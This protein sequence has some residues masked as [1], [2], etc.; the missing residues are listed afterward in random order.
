MN[1]SIYDIKSVFESLAT[2]TAWSLQLLKIN[3]SK[4]SH[5]TYIGREIT[6]SPPGSLLSLVLEISKRYVGE[7]RSELNAFQGIMDYDGSTVDKFIYRLDKSNELISDEFDALINAV[8]KPDTELDPLKFNSKAYVL[9]GVINHKGEE[10]T[11]K[12]ISM[13][14]PVTPLKHKFLSGNGTFKE[15]TEKVLSLRTLID[16]VIVQNTVYMLT[17]S[18]E[19]LFNMERAYKSNCV[20]KLNKIEQC[21]IFTDFETFSSVAKSGHNPR[22]FV[23]FNEDYLKELMNSKCRKKL[24]AT[25]NIPMVGDLFDTKQSGVADKIVK[26]LCKRGM[27]DP[28]SDRPMEVAG[29]K[30]WE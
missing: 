5:T 19:N 20:K 9:L 27:K 11:I 16:V 8:S 23:S 25:F 18:G 12:L 28:F 4:Q 2:C 13:H 10:K 1:M 24:A 21:N 7:E 14:N 6:L 29:S 30:K 22:K 26:L 15:I 3:T 17:F